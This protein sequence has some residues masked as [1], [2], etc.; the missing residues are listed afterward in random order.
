M[1][2]TSWVS[3]ASL[4]DSSDDR[5]IHFVGI[6]GAGMRALAELLARRGV[7]VTGCDANPGATEDLE[8]L[9]IHVETGHDPIHLF[10]VRE[11]VVT[12]AMSRQHPEL[13]RAQALGIP[14]TRRAE[15]LGRA[16]S[17]SRLVGIAGTHGKTT[18]TVMTTSALAAAGLKPTGLAGGRVSS[19]GGNLRY[20]SDELFVVEADEYDRSFLTLAPT[21]A[22]VTNIEADHL[23]IYRDLDDIRD[24][25]SRWVSSVPVIVLCADDAGARSL[26]LPASAEVI[27]Y[28][29]TSADARLV[30]RD[31]KPS[32]HFTSF[33]VF[34]D[35]RELGA[36]TLR[37]P[38]SHNV[39]NALAAI[40]TGLALGA[41][42]DAM[43]PGLSEF[44]GVERRFQYLCDVGGITIVDDYAH[45][46][47]EIAATLQAARASYPGRRI[48]AAFQPHLFTRTRDFSKA[49]ADALAA[50]DIILLAEIY[51]AREQPIPGITSELIAGSLVAAGR[52]VDWQG[53]RSGLADALAERVREGDVVITIGAGDITR[54]GAELKAILSRQT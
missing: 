16:V 42:L 54:T 41:T 30:A 51:P 27:R 15:A 4:I 12:S 40:G 43:S 50:A 11:V 32:G 18:T 10:G 21:V 44:G 48:V 14:V 7:R 23:D 29:L 26:S 33:S 38:G 35:G 46:P 20:E 49:F 36:V 6:A 47:T 53:P 22:V 24:T 34:Y 25:F 28:G 19:W 31:I 9:G 52:T 2:D 1:R 13:V 8:A 37:V 17:D 5:P 45:H 39:Q 3:L